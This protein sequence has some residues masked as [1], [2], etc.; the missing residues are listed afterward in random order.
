MGEDDDPEVKVS[1]KVQEEWWPEILSGALFGDP[2][3]VFLGTLEPNDELACRYAY[4]V[5]KAALRKDLRVQ[6]TNAARIDKEETDGET[7]FM[8]HNVFKEANNYRLQCIRDWITVH[9]D[10][11]RIVVMAGL[12]PYQ[13]SKLIHIKPHGMFLLEAPG[14]ASSSGPK[15]INRA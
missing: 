8:L 14:K 10:C 1:I 11:F 9:E 2:F 7:V 5:M 13:L 12:D 15:K 6:I 3:L 4:E